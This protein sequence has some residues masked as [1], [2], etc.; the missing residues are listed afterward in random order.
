MNHPRT[1]GAFAEQLEEE[2]EEER[3]NFLQ[4]SHLDWA[5]QAAWDLVA[6]RHSMTSMELR[7]M[8]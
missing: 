2:V 4:N 8:I 1:F 7:Q 6:E 5:Q 3:E